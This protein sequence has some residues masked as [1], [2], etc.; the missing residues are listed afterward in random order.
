MV[1]FGYKGFGGSKHL[2]E[3]GGFFRAR[4]FRFYAVAYSDEAVPSSHIRRFGL[5][6][7]INQTLMANAHDV[8][9]SRDESTPLTYHHVVATRQQNVTYWTAKCRFI[10][11]ESG[12]PFF[13]NSAYSTGHKGYW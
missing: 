13:R 7:D 2:K 9:A 5:G 8:Y 10:R 1:A 4:E 6:C 3:P 12:D 11:S